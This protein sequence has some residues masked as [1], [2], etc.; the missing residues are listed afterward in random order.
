MTIRR[1]ALVATNG[2]A[3]V[4]ALV[5]APAGA[6]EEDPDLLPLGIAPTRGPAG[7]AVTASG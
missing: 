6:Q 7:T 1:A 2:L 4:A 5:A 3:L